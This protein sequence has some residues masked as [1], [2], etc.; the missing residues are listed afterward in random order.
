M[1]KK[2]F[3]KKNKQKSKNYLFEEILNV[4]KRNPNRPLNYKQ[5][6]A[7]LRISDHAEKLVIER[8][9]QDMSAKDVLVQ[10]DRGKFRLK[11][12][13]RLVTGT[14]EIIAS[15]AAYVVP[16]NE[17]ED[18]IYVAQ[19]NTLNALHGDTVRVQV[20]PQRQGRKP[21]G[22]IIEIIKRAR[23][24]FVGTIQ[25]SS[26]YAFL[27]P[28]NPRSGTDVYIPLDKLY[29]AKDGQ[30]AIARIVEWPRNALNPIGEVTDVLGDAG[31]NQTEMHAILAEFGLPYSFPK[32]VAKHADYIPAEISEN[33]LRRR[34]DFRDITTFTI[35][36]SDAKDF[37]DALSVRRLPNG[38]WEIGVHIADVSHYVKQDTVIDKEAAQ[39][40]TSVYLVDRVV[41][42]LP[43]KLSNHVCS[44]VPHEDRL[45]FAA[46][47]ELNEQAQV[48][49]EWFG[50]TVIHSDRRFTYEEAQYILETGQGDFADELNLLDRLAKRLRE[51]RLRK[52]SI[53]FEKLEVKFHL[54]EAGNPTGVF[55]KQ[56]KDSNQLIEDF[57]LLA[58]RRVATFI[59]KYS[60]KS[61]AG[62]KTPEPKVQL[63]KPGS[64][65]FV[66][67]VHDRP[68]EEKLA[69]FAEFVGKFGYKLNLQN[70]EKVADNLNKLLKDVQGKPEGNAIEM[71][72]IRS[73]AKA[74]YT[75]KNIGHYGLGFDYYTH[76]TSPIRR[77]PDVMVHRLLQHY[78]DGGKPVDIEQLE[79][80]CKHSSAMEKL[81]ADAERASIKY[82]QVQYL[83]DKIGETFEGIVSGVTEW[84]IFVEIREN[85]CE[86]MV[87][88]R[89]MRD[90]FYYFDEDNYCIIGRKHK[91]K[92]TLGDAVH[93]EVKR[94][95]LARKQLDFILVD[96]PRPK[97]FSGKA[98]KKQ[99]EYPRE[100]K[101]ATPKKEAP[102]SNEKTK[103]SF[104]DEWGFE[105]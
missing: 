95:D 14:A 34:R 27:V 98:E 96:A 42:M 45:C 53:A 40:A 101:S 22:E 63:P 74:I 31:D 77:Y 84:G 75:T 29:G 76:F 19:R 26:R 70:E 43:E 38:N 89:D 17:D 12:Q 79:S 69:G 6:A 94:A 8:L 103:K 46:V 99:A 18:D 30:K 81:A 15:G 10:T 64:L 36:P 66:Y 50:R 65:P 82:K 93:I 58:N 24:E 71:L 78:L 51:A 48:L 25:I 86:G 90:D 23:T 33:E 56:M 32:D 4:L 49:H 11:M 85:G 72:A 91:N 52:G 59:G 83:Q 41:P 37:D 100:R 97:S 73:M 54:D 9:M 13:E 67:R 21:E 28:D 60:A 61:R 62:D 105:V 80:E 44:L 7:E 55:F 102:R 35:D 16:E 68:N 39:R 3:Q 87:R 47:F 20:Y 57:M 104:R 88:I 92:Y 2:K 5:V 1:G